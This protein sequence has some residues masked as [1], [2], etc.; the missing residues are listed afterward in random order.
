MRKPYFLAVLLFG[1][2][3]FTALADDAEVKT[4]AGQPTLVPDEIIVKFSQSVSPQQ[5]DAI[6]RQHGLL[7]KKDSR[8]PGAFTVFKH[9]NPRAVLNTL[10]RYPGVLSVEQNAYA[11]AFG[12]PNDPYYPYQW[13]M[14]RIGMETAWDLSTGAGVVVAVIDTGVKQSLQDMANTQFVAGWD[15]VN[16]DADPTDDEGH[17]SHVA[18]TIA[19][20]TNNGVGVAGVAYNAAIMPIKVLNSRG[21]GTFDDIAEG[22]YYAADHGA[23][24]INMSLGGASTL[25]VLEDAVNYAWNNGVVVV[26][27]AGNESTS[28]P[29][30]P[31]AYTNSISV[32]ATAGN[33]SLASYSN[34][35]STIDL[36]APGGDSGDYNGDGYDDMILQNTFTRTGE[37]Y[38]FFAGTSMASPHVAGVAALVKAANTG[39]TNTQIRD[40]LETTT[41]DLGANGW[42]IYFGHGMVD[43]VAAIQAAGGAPPPANESPVADFTFTTS[44][45]TAYFTDASYD[46][47]GSIASR[48]WNF[49]DGATS[50]ATDPSHAYAAGGTYTVTLTVTDNAGAT[51]SYSAPVTV[52]EPGG[53][54]GDMFVSDISMSIKKAG[55]NY[56][57]TAVVAILD[58]NGAPV[59]NATV[60][61][62]W[63]GVVG[64]S[65]SG[66]TGSNGSVAF[67]AKAK[68][69]GPFV[70]TVNDVT[71]A[72]LTYNPALNV[73]SSDSI[74]Y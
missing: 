28:S 59:A 68:S 49:G 61:V 57:T 10:K 54:T 69:G 42:D 53:T 72:A 55:R 47:D 45:L 35:G 60:Y 31:A 6:A 41:E 24:V 29:S 4:M 52:T 9:A 64:G 56:L 70:I 17:G 20:S 25:T 13:H 19:Q 18:G 2:L 38:Y 50:T 15:F 63:S 16:N 26:C 44:E 21:S 74:S 11:Y 67:T 1:L 51:D 36:C 3:C 23:D 27:A 22:V 37:G 30:Y 12:V 34:Y 48:Y 43:A 14:K 39:L 73:E 33:D 7:K 5:R 71:H 32:S 62:T 46:P 40:I 8:K 66:I 58:Q 65:A